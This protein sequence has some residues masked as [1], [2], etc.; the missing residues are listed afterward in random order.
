MKFGLGQSVEIVDGHPWAGAKAVVVE[1][2][3]NRLPGPY[4]LKIV[5]PG[6]RSNGQVIFVQERYM[7]AA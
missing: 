3:D 2:E 1:C 7:E 6:D 4:R 5:R